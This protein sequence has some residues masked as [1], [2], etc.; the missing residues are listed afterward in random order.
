MT[1]CAISIH[2][3]AKNDYDTDCA[4]CVGSG[5][6]DLFVGKTFEDRDAFKQHM[7]LYAIKNKFAYRSAKSAPSV[8]VLECVGQTCTWRVYAVLVKGSSMYEVRKIGGE[9]SCSVDERAGY[10]RQATSSVIGE[11]LRQQFSGT[12]VGPRPREIRQVMRGDHAVNISYW[13]AWRSREVAVDIAKGSCG[14]S[15]QSLPAYL[16]RLVAANPGTIGHIH[17]EYVEDVGHRFKYMFLAMG[18]C[19]KGFQ[20]M[21]KVV[22]I[23]GTHLKGKYAGC[24]LT[25]SAQDGNYQI[26]P[27]AFAIVDGEND[28]SWEWFFEKLSSFVPNEDGVVFVS[29]RHASIYQGLRK[30]WC[31]CVVRLYFVSYVYV[32]VM[33]ISMLLFGKL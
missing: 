12:G 24:L 20:H 7:A 32:F 21:R 25:A 23:D 1:S 28:K 5:D 4:G 2:S 27:L 22:V 17:T 26:Y 29:D 11:M 3:N 33:R 13:K 14:A 19:V 15:Y 6:K 10:R 31:G 9:H 16:E 30:V 8:M 18:A